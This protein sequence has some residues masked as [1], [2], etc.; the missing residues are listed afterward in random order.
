MNMDMRKK[1]LD[2]AYE[3]HSGQFRKYSKLPYIT[4]PIA[5]ADIALKIKRD[6]DRYVFLGDDLLYVVGILHDTC[7]DTDVTLDDIGVLFGGEARTLVDA[8]TK[9]DGE[10]YLD[11]ILRAKSYLY[12]RIVKIADLTHNLSDL[13]EG[14]QKDKYRLAKYILEN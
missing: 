14:T 8:L 11:S 1:A 3:A 5:V 12:S 6:D 9:R 10:T 7:E 2:F 13:K 4:H